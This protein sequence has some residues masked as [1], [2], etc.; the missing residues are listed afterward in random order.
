MERFSEQ[1][2]EISKNIMARW[3][4]ERRFNTLKSNKPKYFITFPFPY[5][6]G[7][8]HVGHAYSILRV[9]SYAKFKRLQ[10]HNV[11]FPLGFHATGEP[12]VG[13]IERLKKNDQSQIDT[14]KLF[15]ATDKDIASFVK[16][17]KNLVLFWVSRWKSDIENA[18]CSIDWDRTFITA[19][20]S[21]GFN[22]FVEWQYKNYLIMDT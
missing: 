9:D 11:L 20:F 3:K 8:P 19:G 4:E 13:V 2:N 17:P 22:R 1:N 18:G 12:I 16:E 15:G 14:L 6:N 5:V 7:A 21:K 10:G